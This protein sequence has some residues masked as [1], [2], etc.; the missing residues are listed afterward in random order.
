M[1]L[2]NLARIA[3][4]FTIVACAGAAFARSPSGR[5]A[6]AS[7]QD[8]IVQALRTMYA[9]ATTDDLKLF[10]TVAAPDF[11]AFDGGKRYDGDALMDLAKALHAAGSVYV[12]TGQ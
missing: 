8:E 1:N 2:L 10:H 11:Y 6:S 9:A 3:A 12:W 4:V 5:D 7:D